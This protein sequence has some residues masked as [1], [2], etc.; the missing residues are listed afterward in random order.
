[1]EFTALHT[2]AM[3]GHE[4][5]ISPNGPNLHHQSFTHALFYLAA[6][7]D[8]AAPLREEVEMVMAEE[9]GD[10]GSRTAVSKLRKIDSFMRE[11]QRLNGPNAS[12]PRRVFTSL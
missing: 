8:L 12:E 6:D 5:L 3:V 10:L 9:N 11:A 4:F 1:M 7:P 2:T